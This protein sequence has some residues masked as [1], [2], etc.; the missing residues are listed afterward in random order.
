M[1]FLRQVA[2]IYLERE[3]ETLMNACF[4]FPNR[5][6]SLFFRKYLGQQAGGVLFSPP[7]TTINALFYE[8]TDRQPIDR[9]AGLLRLYAIQTYSQF[10]HF[11]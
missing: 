3:R 1:E 2:D 8:L 9:I 7:V 5:R 11:Q 10:Y 4:V 6:S